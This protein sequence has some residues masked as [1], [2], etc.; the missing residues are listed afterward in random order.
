M[1]STAD[2]LEIPFCETAGQT[3]P[4]SKYVLTTESPGCVEISNTRSYEMHIPY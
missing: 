1:L 4:S 3:T 2:V